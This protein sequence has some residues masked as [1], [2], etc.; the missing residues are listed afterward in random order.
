LS[1]EERRGETARPEG[2]TLNPR[3]L[4]VL[5]HAMRGRMS[6]PWPGA[7]RLPAGNLPAD[8]AWVAWRLLGR[9]HREGA[10]SARVFINVAGCVADVDLVHR[11]L[12]DGTAELTIDAVGAMW[13]WSMVVGDQTVAVASRIYHRQRECQYSCRVFLATAPEA[14]LVIP[15]A[16]MGCDLL[17]TAPV[18]PPSERPLS[19]S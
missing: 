5:G 6:P 4:P 18:A 13:S 1:A 15:P 16:P 14:A 12:H 11:A 7:G 3:F 8:G 17:A 10:R 9:N 19:A 2:D